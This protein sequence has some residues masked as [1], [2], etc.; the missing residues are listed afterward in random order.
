MRRGTICIF[1]TFL[2]TDFLLSVCKVVKA[3]GLFN[4]LTECE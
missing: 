2:S 3:I 1:I 4:K